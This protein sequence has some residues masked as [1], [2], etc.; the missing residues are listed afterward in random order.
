MLHFIFNNITKNEKK[1]IL[2]NKFN[3]EALQNVLLD[4]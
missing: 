4:Y 2:F 3:L 1:D